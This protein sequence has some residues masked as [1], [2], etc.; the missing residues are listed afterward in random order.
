MEKLDIIEKSDT[1]FRRV[2]L[3]EPYGSLYKNSLSIS[4][5][6]RPSPFVKSFEELL[7]EELARISQSPIPFED[8]NIQNEKHRCISPVVIPNGHNPRSVPCGRCTLCR[9]ARTAIWFNRFQIESTLSA[10]TFFITLTYN[11]FHV[12]VLN[13]RDYQ[14]FL[15]RL[16]YYGLTFT[17]SILG[18]YGPRGGRPHYHI[19]IFIKNAD[20]TYQSF[21]D[22]AV[23]C[24]TF[25]F[26]DV[27]IPVGNH[28]YYIAGYSKDMFTVLD[29]FRQFS[30][31]TPIGRVPLGESPLLDY[32]EYTGQTAPSSDANLFSPYAGDS[33]SMLRHGYLNEAQVEDSINNFEKEIP[34]NN[35]I[36]ERYSL[37]YLSEYVKDFA[38]LYSKY[39]N[40]KL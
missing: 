21:C 5:Y 40:L 17:Y 8:I 37:N 18:E 27:K 24:W 39:L 6:S 30:L 34:T 16:R 23:S 36:S 33:R 28:L 32:I 9:K 15:K 1:R 19:L 38:R 14:L 31:K 25:G 7:Y 22:L 35:L 4:D 3:L 12:S 26:V 11:D 2:P 10:S 13:K 20:T 29:T